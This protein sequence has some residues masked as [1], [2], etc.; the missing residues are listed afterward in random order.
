MFFPDLLLSH[1]PPLPDLLANMSLREL[2]V[3]LQDVSRRVKEVSEDLV[4]ELEK[5]EELGHELEQQT[6]LLSLQQEQRKSPAK[7]QTKK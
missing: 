4:K 6:E 5:R 2:E 3:A 7:A 1:D